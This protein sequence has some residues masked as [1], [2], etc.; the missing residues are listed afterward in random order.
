M[1]PNNLVGQKFGKLT[2]IAIH[3]RDKRKNLLWA[4]QCECGGNTVANAYDLRVGKVKSCK[5]LS[6][7]GMHTTHG[8]ARSGSKRSK[9]YNI[10][11]AML[12]R[13]NNPN[14]PNYSR[15]G[16]RGVTVCDEWKSF[17]NFYADMGDKPEGKSLDRI[18]NDKGY[19]K[20]NCEWRSLHE[21][22]RNKRSTKFLYYY[23]E[24]YVQIDL[25]RKLGVSRQ[26][27][28][29]YEK[30]YGLSTQEALSKWLL[31]KKI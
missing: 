28:F 26:A 4:C 30:K 29:Y 14:D 22:S 20:E 17:E 19:N 6:K 18:D 15:Y 2:V 16:G 3:S 27:L 5:C 21:Q 1:K 8:M 7:R 13:C 9:E 25:L 10:W 12:Q 23:G 24:K 31:R 11:A